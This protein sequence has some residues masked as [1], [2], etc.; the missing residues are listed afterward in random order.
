MAGGSD[1]EYHPSGLRPLTIREKAC[2]QTFPTDHIFRGAYT[3]KQSQVGNAVPPVLGR[4]VLLEVKRALER[5]DGERTT[6][7]GGSGRNEI[8]LAEKRH[9]GRNQIVLTEEEDEDEDV[10]LD[11]VEIVE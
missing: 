7:E 11:V 9:S 6:V 2:L 5:A 3:K 8:V 4:A 1:Q 10:A